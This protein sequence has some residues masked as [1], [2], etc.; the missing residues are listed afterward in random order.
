MR[1]SYRMGLT[2]DV[3][4]V[5]LSSSFLTTEEEEEEDDDEED[6]DDEVED[7]D[8]EDDDDEEEEEEAAES[9]RDAM[10]CPFQPYRIQLRNQYYVERGYEV[11]YKQPK[12]TDLTEWF[13]EL[14]IQNT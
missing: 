10:F 2:K 14:L 9:A 8:E 4:I 13:R 5:L 1:L 12:M 11:K 3:E 7:D 6:D